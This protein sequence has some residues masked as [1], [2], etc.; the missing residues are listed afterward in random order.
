MVCEADNGG[1][2]LLIGERLARHLAT[3]KQD[4]QLVVLV[5]ISSSLVTSF[6]FSERELEKRL[7]TKCHQFRLDT[8]AL[9]RNALAF[10]I[11]RI[12]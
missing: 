3:E 8:P 1:A 7:Y 12:K 5:S 11:C 6:T 9:A 10:W 4:K 2:H